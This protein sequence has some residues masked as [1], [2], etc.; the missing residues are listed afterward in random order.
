MTN[1]SFEIFSSFFV[2]FSVTLGDPRKLSEYMVKTGGR[3]IPDLLNEEERTV[4]PEKMQ[5][6]RDI[7][8][9]TWPACTEP[10]PADEE[11][12]P[13]IAEAI[14]SNPVSYGHIHCAEA[15][16]IPLHI[17]FPQP[18]YPTKSFPHPLSNMGFASSWSTKNRLSF[19]MVDEFMWL[20]LGSIINEF[21][22]KVF[23]NKLNKNM[24]YLALILISPFIDFPVSVVGP[25]QGWRGREA[26]THRPRSAH[27][28][29]VVTFLC[30]SVCGLAISRRCCRG[31]HPCS[32]YSVQQ[33][34]G[35]R[36]IYYP[37]TSCPSLYPRA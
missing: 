17:M 35:R 21:R 22:I 29:Y 26:P 15:L 12:T 30:P 25:Y 8:F 16:S 36:V 33:R 20:G 34:C 7:T 37:S 11:K 31:V 10:D 5:M 3:L 24:L 9:S 6:L 28:A 18:W 32:F 19:R 14:I 2:C 4:L 13:F 27:L 1:I 23:F